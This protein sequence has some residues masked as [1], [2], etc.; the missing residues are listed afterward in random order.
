MVGDVVLDSISVV[1]VVRGDRISNHDAT[2]RNEASLSKIESS[3]S[4]GLSL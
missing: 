2:E 3:F 4:W 1:S